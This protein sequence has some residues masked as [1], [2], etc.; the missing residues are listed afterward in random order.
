[1]LCVFPVRAAAA[2]RRVDFGTARFPGGAACRE[3]G[4]LE[5]LESLWSILSLR[6]EKLCKVMGAEIPHV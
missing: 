2:A 1:M 3:G 6:V 5:D 4:A